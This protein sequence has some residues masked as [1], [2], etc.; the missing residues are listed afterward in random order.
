MDNE[1]KKDKL[2]EIWLAGGCFWGLEA[3]MAKIKGVKDVTSG[4]ANGQGENPSY[5]EVCTGTSGFAE[6]VHVVYDKTETDLK[7]LLN[8]FFRVV[9]PTTR[10]RQGNDMGHQYRSGIYYK[11]EEDRQSILAMVEEEQKKYSKEIVT[12]VEPLKNYYLAEEY[13]QNYLEK[14]PRGYCHIDFSKLDD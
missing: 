12:E 13:H 1:V 5:E 10:N 3:Y 4:Y 9:D 2:E 8:Y 7:T 11:N 14:N 6:T